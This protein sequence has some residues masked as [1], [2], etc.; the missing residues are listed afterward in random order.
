MNNYGEGMQTGQVSVWV[1]I[2][3]AALGIAGIVAGQLVNSWREERRTS[4]EARQEER[5]HW[6]DKRL[7]QYLEITKA[8]SEI[9]RS[10]SAFIRSPRP[11]NELHEQLEALEVT[12]FSIRQRGIILCSEQT[13]KILS[14][15][16]QHAE[17]LLAAI[18]DW[19]SKADDATL[20]EELIE[21]RS[22]IG[23]LNGN[24]VQEIRLE[25]GVPLEGL[26]SKPEVWKGNGSTF[27]ARE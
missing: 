25:L 23:R 24:L 9:M 20:T 2:V 13:N 4:K 5:K 7:E 19:K 10:L 21:R 17:V 27:N 18:A 8:T 26:D 11:P 6:R 3:V 15:I 16:H 12:F 22:F 14:E 1:P